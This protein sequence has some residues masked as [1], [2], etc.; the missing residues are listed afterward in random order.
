MTADQ[1]LESPTL[2]VVLLTPNAITPRDFDTARAALTRQLIESL[3]QVTG[4]DIAMVEAV[5]YGDELLVRIAELEAIK[6]A[7]QEVWDSVPASY[8]ADDP[9][10][11]RHGRAL[12]GLGAAL[13]QE[14]VK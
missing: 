4:A 14:T 2:H 13:S 9:M 8:D 3:E 10:V 6:R 11:Q 7:A 1:D 12:T 5:K